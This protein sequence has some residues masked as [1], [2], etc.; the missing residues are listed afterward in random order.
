MKSY[1]CGGVYLKSTHPLVLF[2]SSGVQTKYHELI[3]INYT[4]KVWGKRHYPFFIDCKVYPWLGQLSTQPVDADESSHF[5]SRLTYESWCSL[6][7]QS[8]LLVLCIRKTTSKK[9]LPIV[10]VANESRPTIGFI[11][12]D[13]DSPVYEWMNQ[14]IEITAS[15]SSIDQTLSEMGLSWQWI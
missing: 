1:W 5:C 12:V 6:R 10:W 8:T 2:E 3:L 15:S 13:K 9:C 14:E 11:S 4:M 7:K